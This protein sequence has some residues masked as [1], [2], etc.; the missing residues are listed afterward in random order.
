MDLH[1]KIKKKEIQVS[2][3]PSV[4]EKIIISRLMR[5]TWCLF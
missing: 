2:S 5:G 3:F 4:V 1:W